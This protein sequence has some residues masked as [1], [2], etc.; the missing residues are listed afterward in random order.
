LAQTDKKFDGFLE[1][2]Q[3]LI[4]SSK[5]QFEREARSMTTNN[6]SF[7]KVSWLYFLITSALIIVGLRPRIRE[8]F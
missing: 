7:A 5:P 8:F 1:R 3:R 4:D 2:N 6:S